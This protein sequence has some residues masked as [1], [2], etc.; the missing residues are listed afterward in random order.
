MLKAKVYGKCLR[1]RS[2]DN[3]YGQVLRLN[4]KHTV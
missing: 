2:N 4:F 3:I 1:L